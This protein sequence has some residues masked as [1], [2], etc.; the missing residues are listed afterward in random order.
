[1]ASPISFGDAYLMGKLALRLGQAFTKG[2]KS[3][4]A[5]FREVESQL[6]S[7]SQAL[8]ALREAK[9]EAG[10][11]IAVAPSRTNATSQGGQKRDEEPLNAILRS[12]DECLKHLERV[13]E[14]YSCIIEARDSQQPRLKQW[15]RD[16][17]INWKKI[18]WT[19]EG[20]DLNTLRSQLTVHTNALNL[21]LGVATNSQ[22]RRVE[23]S[24]EQISIM[25]REI[26]V[27]FVDNLKE[28]PS[29][30]VPSA[31]DSS[32]SR[33]SAVP[34]QDITFELLV[35]A[36]PG[37]APILIC[38]CATLHAKW[39]VRTSQGPQTKLFECRCGQHDEKPHSSRVAAYAL[40]TRTFPIR[41]AGKQKSW[42]IY[43]ATNTNTNQLITVVVKKVS[44]N[45]MAEFEQTFIQRLAAVRAA[46]MFHRSETNMLAY[47]DPETQEAR[48]LHLIA[49]VGNLHKSVR[50]IN[51][52]TGLRSYTRASTQEIQVLHYRPFHGFASG[53]D[54]STA[55][56]THNSVL[57]AAEIVIFF[58]EQNSGLAN[59]ISRVVL[60]LTSTKKPKLDE[61]EAAVILKNIECAGFKDVD[62]A[63]QVSSLDVTFEFNTV[64]A[65]KAFHQKIEDMRM[66][67][68]VTGLQHPQP[69]ERMV[70]R[71]LQASHVRSED[72]DIPDADITIVQSFQTQLFRLIIVSRN[73]CS[74]LSQELPADFVSS[75]S[76]PGGPNLKSRAYLVQMDHD[77]TQKLCCYNQGFQRLEFSHASNDRLFELGLAAIAGSLP[78]RMVT[79][80]QVEGE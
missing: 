69:G 21:V 71:R 72:V 65:A 16:I 44:L 41:L 34:L 55:E 61:A 7:L 79:N 33:T 38:S 46:T 30:R 77:A 49:D 15:T 35:D 68:F 6:H 52:S 70:L 42:M 58:N 66:E 32:P 37:K 19:T 11:G 31:T 56:I 63:G 43:K 20:G 17:K 27:W 24:V 67:L 10:A 76:D 23:A 74:I 12:C 4:P 45:G 57:P 78:V 3:A 59:D 39:S 9:N 47:I 2:R 13:V 28:R 50:T 54:A 29:I 51:F 5:E 80:M 60:H 75:L 40:S 26:H 18:A 53:D 48:L 62:Q 64:E 73:G 36:G 22:A 1:M 25:L 8:C 14:K